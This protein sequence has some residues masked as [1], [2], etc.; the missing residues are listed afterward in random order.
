MVALNRG[1]AIAVA[2]LWLLWCVLDLNGNGR[3]TRPDRWSRQSKAPD[4]QGRAAMRA[5]FF[6]LPLGCGGSRFA[7]ERPASWT[8]S[9][10]C[11]RARLFSFLF[12]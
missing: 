9:T 3:R 1:E 4:G 2:D 11:R 5:Q 6:S 7:R 10:C 12:F 8:R